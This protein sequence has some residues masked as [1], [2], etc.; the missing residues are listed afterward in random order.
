MTQR[1]N[2]SP[3]PRGGAM[4]KAVG[5]LAAAGALLLLGACGKRRPAVADWAA[6]APPSAVMGVSGQAGWILGQPAFQ[7]YLEKFPYADQTLDLFLK[8]ARINPHKDS[9]RISL[10]VTG[11]PA[12]DQP[13]GLQDLDKA[14]PEFL[15]QLGGFKDQAAVHV[16][17]ADAF[18]AEGSLPLNKH[19]L[20]VYVILD[21]NQYHIRAV[22]DP[23]GRVWLGDLR[24]LA[25]LESGGLPTANPVRAALEW[26]NGAA[27]FQ[28]FLRTRPLL[29]Q[30]PG[31]VPD[32]VLRNLP[33][34]VEGLAWSVT[35]GEG[36]DGLHRFELA[37]SGSA[38]G[39]VKVAPWVQR[40]VAAAT[41][42]QG[43]PTAQAPEILQ[44]RTRI[45]VRCQLTN[46][47]INL[48]LARL[49]QPGLTLSSRKP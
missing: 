31:K 13:K 35:P 33:T 28:G 22:A 21:V 27:P 47:Q 7:A 16:A 43:A 32:E 36:K 30:L 3:I 25:K 49:A 2:T 34:G 39:V 20:P 18:P 23:A 37:V 41:S 44:E 42:L 24:T 38:E 17:I 12:G 45:G 26:T 8:K 11:L 46:E 6:S 9:G 14:V 4:A 10:Y 40:F 19:E 48:A 29:D 5:V 15:I 1:R